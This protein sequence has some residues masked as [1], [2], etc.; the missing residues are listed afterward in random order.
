MAQNVANLSSVMKDAW[1]SN[2]LAKQFYNK[3]PLLDWMRQVQP[4]I[5]GQ[6]AQVPIHKGRAGA[7]TSTGPAGGV[8]NPADN[9][10][11]DQALYT[12][13]YLWRQVALE[14]AALNQSSG[15]GQSIISAKN[16]E[17][18]GAIDDMSASASRQ[19]AN[20][21][22]GFIAQ[23]TT[24]G[25]SATINL[26]PQA[27]GGIGYDAIVRGWFVIGQP[28]DVGTAGDSDALATGSVIVDMAEDPV[29]PTLTISNSVTTTSSHFVSIANPNSA[30]ATNPELN[31]LRNM[32]GSTGTFGG[33]N[34]ASAGES[35][36]K[37]ALV[38]STTTSFSIDLALNLQRAAWQKTGDVMSYVI[39]SGKQLSNFYS[40]LQNQVRFNGDRGLS[41]GGIGNMDGLTWNNVGVNAWQQ[42]VD[43]EWY[44]VG[45]KD[46][47]VRI[48][49][50]YDKPTWTSEIEGGGE[51]LRWGQGTTAFNEGLVMGLQVGTQR[52]NSL[53]A[54]T[55]LVA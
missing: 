14:T 10:H 21:G 28:V 36:W 55:N 4:T 22:D 12:M 49:G 25:A 11:L 46:D 30:T 48:V 24:G 51:G 34:P 52:R 38:D 40:L 41:A 19:L 16:L 20:N 31:G 45:S 15:N 44:H 9:Q 18:Q 13:V 53:S 27:S 2:R 6:Q 37:P 1:T 7:E 47:L 50:N 39:T 42:I 29:T 3:N 33:I 26:L 32:A 35:F 5:I 17:I 23:C 43:K 8:L 54:A